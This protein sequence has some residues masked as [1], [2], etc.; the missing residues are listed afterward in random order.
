M[1]SPGE[2]QVGGG[3]AAG[4]PGG[5]GQAHPSLHR[6]PSRGPGLNIPLLFH[7]FHSHPTLENYCGVLSL[8][9]SRCPHFYPV[10]AYIH[11]SHLLPC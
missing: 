5:V 11:T 3:A 9:V 4:L 10:R 1:P 6:A 8:C 2:D 7:T